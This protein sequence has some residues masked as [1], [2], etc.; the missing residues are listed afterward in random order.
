MFQPGPDSAFRRANPLT[1]LALVAAVAAMLPL[2]SAPVLLAALA[3]VLAG[4][5]ALGFGRL[6]A[7]RLVLLLAPLALALAVVH[8]LLI[9]RGPMADCGPLAC[10][11][12]GLA[13]AALVFARL[14]LLLGICLVFVM[15]TRPSDLARALDGAGVPPSVSYLLTAP[16]ALVETVKEEARQIRDSLQ[17]RG[18]STRDGLRVRVRI[19]AAM[20]NPLVRNMI[21]EAPVR[22]EVL[23]MRGF[24]AFPRRGLIDPI[25]DGAAE[26]RLRRGLLLLALL[27]LG[28][29]VAT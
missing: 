16:L 29:A 10:Y 14:A 9:A 19:L 11:P 25:E 26:V 4:A 1:R 5:A 3:A 2:W 17:L 21:T 23:E 8:G 7:R 15:T 20:V 12:E 6:L 28:L 24:R 13:H 22:A 18:L 27:Q